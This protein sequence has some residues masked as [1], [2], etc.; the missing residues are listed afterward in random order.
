MNVAPALLYPSEVLPQI[1]HAQINS[2]P[3]LGQES[4]YKSQSQFPPFKTKTYQVISVAPT[5]K[6]PASGVKPP[7]RQVKRRGVA[8]R[9]SI[10]NIDRDRISIAIGNL[11]EVATECIGIEFCTDRDD[12]VA[13]L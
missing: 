7:L 2:D 8:I 9:A 3:L 11:Q 4:S 13:I 1:T 12:K 6:F 10:S 5:S